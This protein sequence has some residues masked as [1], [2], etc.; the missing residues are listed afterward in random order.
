MDAPESIQIY[1]GSKEKYIDFVKTIVKNNIRKIVFVSKKSKETFNNIVDKE[2]IIKNNIKTFNIKN[3]ID[4]E[5]IISK[6]NEFKEI[7]NDTKYEQLKEIIKEH[8]KNGNIIFLNVG[9]HSKEKNL[10]TLVKVFNNII[11]NS[12]KENKKDNENQNQNQKEDEYGDNILEK[13]I[14]LL[15]VGDGKETKELIKYV[16]ENKLTNRIIFLGNKKNPYPYFKMADYVILTSLNEGYPVVFQEAMI[17]DKK[18]ITTDVSD[19]VIDIKE[20]QRGYIISFDEKNMKN[21]II[22]IVKKEEQQ[23]NGIKLKKYNYIEENNINN[24]KIYKDILE[25]VKE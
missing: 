22:E 12:E 14:Y 1:F 2:Y 10:I 19:A 15:M 23:E 18:I 16:E 11:K 24:D 17:L 20:Q 9:R 3:H 25:L 21:E 4:G 7:E 13:K 8:N 6:S 5:N